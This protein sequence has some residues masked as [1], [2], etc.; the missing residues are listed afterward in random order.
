MRE[1]RVAGRPIGAD[2]P[3]FV[4]A[5]IG[6]NH[7]GSLDRA[8]ALV[9]A[10]A[11]A[12]ADA[13]KFQSFTAGGMVNRYLGSVR[14]GAPPHPAWETLERL[15]LPPEWHA[16]LQAHAEER[17]VVF[18]SAP[19]EAERAALLD[20]ID[21]AAFK[22]ASSE[23]TNRPFLRQVAAYG[24]PVILSTGLATLAEVEAAAATLRSVGL[25]EFALLHCV[26]QYP[27][28]FAE[29][30]LRSLQAL[31]PLAPVVGF[32]DHTPGVT[33][34]LGAVALGARIIEKHVTDDRRRPGPDHPYALELVELATLVRS[35]RDLEAALGDGVKR[36][37][38][39]EE[40]E[41]RFSFRGVYA[42]RPLAAGQPLTADDLKCVRPAAAL[43]PPDVAALVGQ[44]L[45]VDVPVHAALT[46]ADLG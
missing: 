16:P 3:T 35:L 22:L 40:V 39:N 14:D 12:G 36:P 19:F 42:A 41:R 26:A 27:P 30:N 45:A 24:R 17:G 38:P 25:T 32:S 28:A 9:D 20:G 37:S 13:V 8:R 10:A 15:T 23:I 18:L 33:A 21:V 5:E 6:S 4:I 34:A 1:I 44:R 7:D 31:A 43:A 2:H 11:A 46:W 29:L